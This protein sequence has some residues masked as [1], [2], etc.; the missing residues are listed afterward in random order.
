MSMSALEANKEV[1]GENSEGIG[2]DMLGVP[3]AGSKMTNSP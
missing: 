1:S 2:S 3:G